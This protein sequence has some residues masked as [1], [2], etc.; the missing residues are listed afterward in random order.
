MPRP[1]SPSIEM[2]RHTTTTARSRRKAFALEMLVS[3]IA[4]A[5]RGIPAGRKGGKSSQS[6]LQAQYLR[7]GVR[8]AVM[9]TSRV[10]TQLK[11]I[12]FGGVLP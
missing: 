9:S 1:V 2:E 10:G 12:G 7:D 4:M 8:A 6:D 5:P 11:A 3:A